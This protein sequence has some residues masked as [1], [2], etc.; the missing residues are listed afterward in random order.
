M[1]AAAFARSEGQLAAMTRAV[2]AA[3]LADPWAVDA[4]LYKTDL[5][6]WELMYRGD[7]P[8]LRKRWAE[9]LDETI[10][11]AGEN[12]TV[13]RSAAQQSLHLYQRFGDVGDLK[14]AD[15]RLRQASLW[16]PAD[17]AL[18]AQRAATAG[19]MGRQAEAE[20]LSTEAA[21]LAELGDNIE[22]HLYR[23]MIYVVQQIGASVQDG[24]RLAPATEVLGLED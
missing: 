4:S 18:M 15:E 13:Y 2:D 21:R 10:H 7:I 9:Q 14:L 5:L 1:K 22:R 19:A 12:P 6:R 8:S 16:S 23:Q 17:H 11:R 20:Q 24:P 3:V